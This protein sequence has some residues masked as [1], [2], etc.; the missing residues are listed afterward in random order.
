MG[1]RGSSAE[2]GKGFDLNVTLRLIGYLKPY[3]V[4][5][6]KAFGFMLLAVLGGL[7]GPI[8]IGRAIDDGLRL[9]HLGTE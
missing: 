4:Q 8:V 6:V 3:K 2:E 1:L 7:S 5:V 9:G